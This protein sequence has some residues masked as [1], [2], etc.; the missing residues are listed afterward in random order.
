[1]KRA[2]GLA[3][4]LACAAH[5]VTTAQQAGSNVN[6]LPVFVFDPIPEN[7]TEAEKEEALVRGDLFLQ[8]QVEPAIAV[9][10]RNPDHL[11]AAFNDYRAVDFVPDDL[12]LGERSASAGG[13]GGLFARLFGSGQV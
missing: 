4:I 9:S 10:T 11:L 2:L 12:G 1:M 7:P 8:R 13:L 6:V 5:A 3:V